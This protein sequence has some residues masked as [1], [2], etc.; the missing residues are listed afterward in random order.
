MAADR[1]IR[2]G[3]YVSP[4]KYVTITVPAKSS[5]SRSISAVEGTLENVDLDVAGYTR[6]TSSVSESTH[7]KWQIDSA[8]GKLLGSGSIVD[9]NVSQD[10]DG[11]TSMEHPQMYWEMHDGNDTDT[12]GQWDS[13]TSGT[14]I[15][16]DGT[17]LTEGDPG[18]QLSNQTEAL[19]YCYIKNVGS[20]NA[21]YVSLDGGTKH[22]I[23]IS[24]G[25][26]FSCRGDGTNLLANEIKVMHLS[27]SS[28]HIEFVVAI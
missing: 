19:A 27:T 9:N 28:S 5:S 14:G 20:S 7:N 18:I 2:I 10:W 24:A 8:V 4:Q 15:C 11:W 26:A 16:W 12:D 22:P 6:S 21:V 3:T 23:K 13:A 17:R 1:R 25:A